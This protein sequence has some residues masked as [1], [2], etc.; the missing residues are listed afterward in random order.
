MLSKEQSFLQ[1][2]NVGIP[3]NVDWKLGAIDYI[4]KMFNEGG[5]NVKKFHV[6]K[7]YYSVAY[8]SYSAIELGQTNEKINYQLRFFLAEMYHFLNVLSMLSLN[9]NT[10]FLDV[11]CGSGWTAHF[12]AKL[13]LNVVGFD[14]SPD[15]IALA[16]ERLKCD[17]FPTVEGDALP[18]RFLVHDIEAAPLPTT[19]KFDVALFESALHHFVD[20]IST[21]K[22]VSQNLGDSGIIFIIE[23]VAGNEEDERQRFSIMEKYKTLER[24]YTREQL[25]TILEFAGFKYYQFLCPVNGFFQ[26]THLQADTVKNRILFDKSWNITIAAR[27]SDVLKDSL[28]L[29]NIESDFA[30]GFYDVEWA[31]DK[32]FRWAKPKS[33]ISLLPGKYSTI[34]LK[35]SSMF[36]N[37]TTKYQHI[38]VSLNGKEIERFQLH[39]QQNQVPFKVIDIPNL[40]DGATIEIESDSVFSPLW[41]GLNDTRMLSFMVELITN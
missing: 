3:K 32:P 17:P 30:D 41:F 6:M 34:K 33:T 12:L 10:K 8:S 22:N 40:N 16:E 20:P 11:A 29:R 37:Y 38:F 39:P 36:P 2:L 1:S 25:S 18:A 26:E 14:I 13:K 21:L 4:A 19:E 35:I 9:G 15:M 7:P 23:G 31:N 5:E 24:P 28:G 27:K